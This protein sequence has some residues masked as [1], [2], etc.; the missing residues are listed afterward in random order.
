MTETSG[1]LDVGEIQPAALYRPFWQRLPAFFSQLRLEEETPEAIRRKDTQHRGLLRRHGAEAVLGFYDSALLPAVDRLPPG[2]E[3]TRLRFE[4]GCRALAIAGASGADSE[5]VD[6]AEKLQ[7]QLPRARFT[8]D[9]QADQGLRRQVNDF[10]SAQLGMVAE[11]MASNGQP[12]DVLRAYSILDRLGPVKPHRRA[13][14][15]RLRWKANDR[16][17]RAIS[18]Y[19]RATT[20]GSF[21]G[22]EGMAIRKFLEER[23]SVDEKQSERELSDRLFFNLLALSSPQP[24]EPSL[25]NAGLA[26]LR[27]GKP[28]RGI[29]YLER[30]QPTGEGKDDVTTGGNGGTADGGDGATAFYLGQAYFQTEDFSASTEAFEQSVEAGYSP[31][32]I[33]AWLGVAYARAGQWEKAEVSFRQAEDEAGEVGE[34]EFYVQWGRACFLMKHVADAGDRFRRAAAVDPADPRAPYGLSVCLEHEGRAAEAGEELSQVASGWPDFSPAV[35]RL[36]RFFLETGQHEEALPHLRR[37]VELA[38]NDPEYRLSLGLALDQTGDGEALAHLE[39]AGRSGTGGPEVLRRVAL[40]YYRQGDRQQGQRWFSALAT[41]ADDSAAVAQFLARDQASQAVEAFNAGEY[42][43]AIDL[44][45]AVTSAFPGDPVVAERFALALAHD[46]SSRLRGGDSGRAWEVFKKARRLAPEQYDCRFFHAVGQWAQGDVGSALAGLHGLAE[47]HAER[48]GMARFVAVAGALRGDDTGERLVQLID[49]AEGQQKSGLLLLRIQLAVER[50]EFSAAAVAVDDWTSNSED[51][52]VLSLSRLQANALVAFAKLRATRRKRRRVIRFL[53]ELSARGGEDLWGSAE[54]LAS[55]AIAVAKGFDR[56]AEANAETLAGC[57]AS[58]LELLEAATEEERPLLL[59]ALSRLLRFAAAHHV[60]RGR[61]A[62]ALGC[63]ER[64][65]EHGVALAP[66]LSKLAAVLRLRLAKPSHERAYSLLADDPEAARKVWQE[67][68]QEDPSDL[69]ARHHL[70]CLAWSRAYDAVLADDVGASLELWRDGLEQYRGLYDSEAY[71]QMLRAKGRALGTTAAHPFDEP[72][73]EAWRGEALY[74]LARKPLELIFHHLAGYDL[75]KRK[76]TVDPRIATA[77]SLMEVLRSSGLDGEL[78]QRLSDDLAD[79]YLDPD[80]TQVP[81]H[82]VSRRRAETVVDIDS[83]NQKARVFLLRSATYEIDTQRKEGDRAFASM[84]KRLANLRR[85]ADWLE[86]Q[87]DALSQQQRDR[88][89][90]TLVAYYELR[91]VIKHAEGQ[92]ETGRFN[93]AQGGSARDARCIVERI[94]RCY[95]ESDNMLKKSLALDPVN[96]R[97]KDLIQHHESQYQPLQEGLEQLSQ[98]GRY[99]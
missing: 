8:G 97:A 12:E 87:L 78:E 31:L 37:A 45:E 53:Q 48:P 6:R 18:L 57:E 26:Y 34:G 4:V 77:A 90:G 62:A 33:A 58:Y 64:L 65:E 75:T 21:P 95:R 96:A 94:Q 17:P 80:P 49:Q 54:V 7:G 32:R 88:L 71:W 36:G 10:L 79:H 55:H 30:A 70:A 24:P 43:R 68:L 23:L 42:R 84:A 72:A 61:L 50:G 91:G 1:A 29:P 76:K 28:A 93:A 2:T 81:D 25:R 9:L 52:R 38:P 86:E 40:A 74:M 46:G 41:V 47:E 89:V 16:S 99:G 85:H 44:W 51:L 27:L 98:I 73:F 66:A 83:A 39:I 67:L 15:A 69:Q 60:S 35:H 56:A 63:L 19:I 59:A 20:N 22:L 92:Q 11:R 3:R 14:H 13:T 5:L 82:D